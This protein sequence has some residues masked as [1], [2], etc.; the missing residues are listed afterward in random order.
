MLT[1]TT[2]NLNSFTSL[3]AP[4]T[5]SQVFITSFVSANQGEE[6]DRKLVG[7]KIKEL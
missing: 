2:D 4:P 5:D 7:D 1:L 3:E 6:R